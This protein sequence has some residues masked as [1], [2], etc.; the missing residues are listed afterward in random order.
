MEKTKSALTF[1]LTLIIKDRHG[2]DALNR[3][4]KPLTLKDAIL[5]SIEQR[6]Q[7]DYAPGANLGFNPLTSVYNKV[8]M[9]GDEVTLTADQV[10]AV[11]DRVG[12]VQGPG[13]IHRGVLKIMNPAIL[14]K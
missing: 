14:D 8:D 1:D 9:A 3:A 11:C 2:E 4:G 12:L 10:T 5:D 6:V 13:A 7:A